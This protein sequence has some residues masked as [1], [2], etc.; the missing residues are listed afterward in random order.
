MIH[1]RPPWG[2]KTT[3]MVYLHFKNLPIKPFNTAPKFWMDV[4][5]IIPLSRLTLQLTEVKEILF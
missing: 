3:Q 2:N 5:D 4:H 1:E